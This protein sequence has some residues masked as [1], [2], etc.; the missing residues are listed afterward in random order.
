MVDRGQGE[1]KL[2]SPSQLARA[3]FSLL[4]Q[5]W[6]NSR[7][8][9]GL[10][11]NNLSSIQPTED[12]FKAYNEEIHT[13]LKTSVF[14]SDA[15]TSWWGVGRGDKGLVTVPGPDT[16]YQ[17]LKALSH[18]NWNDWLAVEKV[19]SAATTTSKDGKKAA[20]AL[21]MVDVRSR[22]LK[23]R[24]RKT[25]VWTSIPVLLVV[26]ARLSPE[27]IRITNAVVQAARDVLSRVL[28]VF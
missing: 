13:R 9:R 21:R 2:A 28:A 1:L 15:C 11:D 17:Y 18:I 6:Y 14:N 3:H 12:A 16:S 8:I 10:L 24:A 19:G 27:G 26:L 23:R 5:G 25:V 20:G 4:L 22:V 7:L